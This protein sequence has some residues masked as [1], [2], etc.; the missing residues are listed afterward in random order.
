MLFSIAAPK[1]HKTPISGR[2]V[3]INSE[4]GGR[5]PQ[6]RDTKAPADR[7]FPVAVGIASA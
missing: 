7:N 5:K 6:V 3:R 4:A 1:A 2:S